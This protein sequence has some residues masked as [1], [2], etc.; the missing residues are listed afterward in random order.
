MGLGARPQ[1]GGTFLSLLRAQEAS[2]TLTLAHVSLNDEGVLEVAH[3]LASSKT[4]RRLDLTGSGLSATGVFHLAK[5]IKQNFTLESLVLKHNR[6]GDHGEAGLAVLCRALHGNAVLRHL[7][8]RHAGL[9]GTAA[10]QVLGELLRHNQHLT[11]L[12]LS[13]NNFGAPGGQVLYEHFG[14]NTTIF[15]CQLTGCKIAEETL[16]EIAQLMLR[17]RKAK[18]ADLRAGPYRACI[19]LGR[20]PPELANFGGPWAAAQLRESRAQ[21][22]GSR[23]LPNADGEA[24][25]LPDIGGSLG[26][27]DA[28]AFSHRVVSDVAS[29]DL[30]M[31]LMMYASDPSKAGTTWAD[32]AA[33]MAEYIRKASSKL[34]ED[35]DA[36]PKAHE[37]LQAIS[38]FFKGRELR[39]RRRVAS[40]QEQ[41]LELKHET[42][43]LKGIFSRTAEELQ[44]QREARAQLHEDLSR[45]KRRYEAEEGSNQSTVDLLACERRELEAR[46][47]VLEE[48]SQR[49]ARDNAEMRGR[50][51]RLRQDVTLLR[52]PEEAQPAATGGLA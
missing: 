13:W 35:R 5:A 24:T 33:E 19:D 49:Q 6:I 38:D 22:E 48:Q 46:L 3:F 14:C 4:L 16:L 40:L 28:A 12:E 51:M 47:A 29:N 30:T 50:A 1:G 42:L 10:A 18:G 25:G 41:L 43:E 15:D 26:D 27:E 45:D 17:N 32:V 44:L 36:V 8:L 31:R 37:H 52:P 2:P 20:P 34:M 7:D 23:G 21:G 11:H 39:A 9:S